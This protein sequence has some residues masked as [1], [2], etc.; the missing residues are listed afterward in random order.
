MI[1][2]RQENANDANMR[3]ENCRGELYVRPKHV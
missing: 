2:I 1:R 3:I